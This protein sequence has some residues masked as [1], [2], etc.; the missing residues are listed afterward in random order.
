MIDCGRELRGT[1]CE[2]HDQVLTPRQKALVGNNSPAV[3]PQVE[4]AAMMFRFRLLQMAPALRPLFL[5]PLD[6]PGPETLTLAVSS[7]SRLEDLQEPL[8]RL[9]A[10]HPGYGVRDEN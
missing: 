5:R 3:A 10:C 6:E 9:G 7:L 4:A 2:E 8:A 1:R